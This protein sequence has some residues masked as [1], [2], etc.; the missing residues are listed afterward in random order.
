MSC[1]ICSSLASRASCC[2][3]ACVFTVL[4]G[5]DVDRLRALVA[6]LLFKGD[7]RALG[8][9]A[10]A[11]TLDRAVMHEE[12]LSAV[13]G[14]DEPEALVVVEPLYGS[15]WHTSSTESVCYVRGGS[16]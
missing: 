6:G 13:L 7:L 9:G 5:G 3:C 15:R 12:I 8:E 2:R 10:E 4:D 16:C 14:G 1:C 11:V